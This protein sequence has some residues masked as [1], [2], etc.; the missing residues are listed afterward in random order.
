MEFSRRNI[1]IILII[2]VILIIAI[3]YKFSEGF[4]LDE[5]PEDGEIPNTDDFNMNQMVDIINKKQKKL[6]NEK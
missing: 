2:I 1:I 3:Y 6:I 5:T 4:G